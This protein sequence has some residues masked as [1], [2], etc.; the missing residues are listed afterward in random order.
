MT[1]FKVDDGL[2]S[3]RKA[4]RA[5]V[6]AMG[7][8]VLAGSWAS[9][10]LTDGWVPDYIAAR[11]DPGQAEKHAAALV[12]AGLWLPDEHD[13]ERGW[14]FH[15]WD[16]HQPTAKSVHDQRA[17]A[18]DRMSRLREQ[19]R[20][21]RKAASDRQPQASSDEFAD[22]SREQVPNVPPN[23]ER[24]SL[25]PTRPDPTRPVLPTEV[26]TQTFSRADAQPPKHGIRIPADFAVTDAM[27]QWA[28]EN[29]PNVDG[30]Y[31]TAQFIDYWTAK[32]GK[33]ATKTDWVRTWQTWMRKAQKDAGQVRG[34]VRRMGGH[35]TFKNSNPANAPRAWRDD[36]ADVEDPDAA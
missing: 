18:K 9:D 28:R 24:S 10:Q 31:E 19:R 29:T 30:H 15:Q 6:A 12:K 21:D 17:A 32:S 26:R 14:W 36:L 22:C 23:F 8:W 7:L 25:T 3:H 33:D 4:V 20:L 5:G 13:G 2:H 1:W 34:N 35:Q 27:R 11:L 16:D